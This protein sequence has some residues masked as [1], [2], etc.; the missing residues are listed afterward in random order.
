[1]WYSRL[2]AILDKASRVEYF[3]RSNVR[4]HGLDAQTLLWKFRAAEVQLSGR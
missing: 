4:L 2:D 3:N 1:M